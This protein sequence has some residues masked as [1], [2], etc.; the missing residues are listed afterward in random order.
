MI[1]KYHWG[2]ITQSEPIEVY[3]DLVIKI[4][5]NRLLYQKNITETANLFTW[6]IQHN[7]FM[8]VMNAQR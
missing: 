2:E 1:K 4:Y 8:E 6:D 7:Q 3:N 5:K